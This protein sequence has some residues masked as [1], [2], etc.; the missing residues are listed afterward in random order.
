MAEE[1]ALEI[2]PAAEGV[3]Q[4]AVSR[5]GHGVDGQI[6]PRQILLE[7][8]LGRSVE[9]EAVVTAP[10]LALGAGQR[11]LFAGAGV[12][13]DREVLAHRLVAQRPQCLGRGAHGDPVAV[14][15]R[16]AEQPVAHGAAD[17][18]ELHADRW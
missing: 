1:A 8:D 15:D 12:Q 18:E 14:A 4:R 10:A 3:D 11:H 2:L 9:G 17:D 16:L 7:R 6:A 5:L 13:E